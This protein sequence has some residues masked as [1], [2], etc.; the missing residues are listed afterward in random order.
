[1]FLC[2]LM[3]LVSGDVYRE[4]VL[5]SVRLLQGT[6]TVKL[7]YNLQREMLTLVFRWGRS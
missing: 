7:V 4:T 3:N 2:L 5:V 6:F 1:M